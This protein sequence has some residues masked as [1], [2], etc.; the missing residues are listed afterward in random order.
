M[1]D[2]NKNEEKSDTMFKVVMFIIVFILPVFLM[3]LVAKCTGSKYDIFNDDPW[4]PRHTQVI[5]PMKK[6]VNVII[7]PSSAIAYNINNVYFCTSIQRDVVA[8]TY[9]Y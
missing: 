8:S 9:Q 3:G 2:K 1:K 4:E 5:K 6:N 7:F